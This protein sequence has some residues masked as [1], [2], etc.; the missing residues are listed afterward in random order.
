MS[1]EPH[2]SLSAPARSTAGLGR[3]AAG[4]AGFVVVFLL[5]SL[6]LSALI[7]ALSRMFLSPMMQPFWVQDLANASTPL[8][9]LLN[10]YFFVAMIL[11][12]RITLWLIHKRLLS[13]LLGPFP[14][15]LVHFWRVIKVLIPI[16]LITL[17][18]PASEPLQ[19]TPNLD[20]G[21]WVVLLPVTLIGLLI[22]TSAEELI[23]RGYLQSQ[24][25]ARFR[26]PLV[27][28]AI[29]S[30]LFAMMHFNPNIDE[31]SAWLVVVWALVF[32]VITADLTARSGTLGPAIALH[33]ANNV[34]AIAIA[35]PEGSFDGVALFTYPFLLSDSQLM[36]AWMPVEML[37]ML[38]CW[39]A[40]RI[41]LRV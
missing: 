2:K 4:V 24:L 34:M 22:Q 15:V 32:A 27:W 7:N 26:H 6:M 10:L 9:A 35:A 21:L 18:L 5:I 17:L 41:A 39:L 12:L 20:F 38:C 3:L 13:S 16:Y 14:L 33:L 37:I 31:T 25:A 11:A 19:L 29:P 28:I 23:F 1:Y 40:A 8:T 30:V 36:M